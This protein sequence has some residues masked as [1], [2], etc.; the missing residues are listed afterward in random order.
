MQSLSS[1]QLDRR[2]NTFLARKHEEFP[3]LKLRPEAKKQRKTH[4]FSD[5]V[6]DFIAGAKWEFGR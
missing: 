4:S 2:I 6:A 3:E 1:Q 5:M